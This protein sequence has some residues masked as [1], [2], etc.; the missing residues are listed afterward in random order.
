MQIG[1]RI[2]LF[3]FT[4]FVVMM[5][6]SALLKVFGFTGY[7]TAYGIDYSQL[8]IFCLVWGMGGAFISLQMSRWMAKK[9][10]GVQVID[11]KRAGGYQADLVERVHR[12]ARSAG[13]ETMPE[14]GIYE[15]PELN[16]FATGPSKRRSLVA[17]STGLLD[18]M[19]P[20]ELDGVLGH[21]LSH[22]ANGDMVTMTLLQG[23][24]NAF[25]MFL[26]RVISF[27][28]AQ[29]LRDRNERGEGMSYLVQS[30]ITFALEIVFMILGSM[31]VAAFSRYREYRADAGGARLAGRESMIAALRKLQA[32]YEI[33]D[34]QANAPA[35]AAMKI[36]GHQ[37]G[38]RALFSTHPAL[39]ARISR[40]ESARIG[41]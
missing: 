34:P 19:S 24:V 2:F 10:M 9:F 4:N 16:A 5:T 8:M 33:V 31:V 40:L 14:V 6:V 37:S 3:L 20:D 28:I 35:I 18:R 11:P 13:L 21:E 22:V 39:T 36:S 17:V 1:K 41:G 27:A 38:F 7:M 32:T 12:L 23:V 25:V 30:L 29:A 26:A 15:S